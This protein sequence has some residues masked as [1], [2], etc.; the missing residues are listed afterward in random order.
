M[1][2]LNSFVEII[3]KTKVKIAK[4]TCVYSEDINNVPKIN[5]L[6]ILLF[7]S[8]KT[9]KTLFLVVSNIGFLMKYHNSKSL[10]LL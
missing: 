9:I 5:P 3:P 7:D 8:F 2:L 4:E 10:Y 1:S 6:I